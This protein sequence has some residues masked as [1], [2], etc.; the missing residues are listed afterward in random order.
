M[1]ATMVQLTFEDHQGHFV[2]Q[3]N[4]RARAHDLYSNFRD[5]TTLEECRL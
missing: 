5:Q 3:W 4:H 2:V 1:R